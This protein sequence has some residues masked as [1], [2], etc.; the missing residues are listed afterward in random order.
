MNNVTISHCNPSRSH[1]H[2]AEVLLCITIARHNNLSNS[3]RRRHLLP[4]YKAKRL[5]YFASR[6][7]VVFF[8]LFIYHFL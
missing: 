2:F 6:L 5:K 1:T 3:K 4:A 8:R 7:R